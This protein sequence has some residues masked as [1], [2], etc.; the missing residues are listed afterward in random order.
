MLGSSCSPCCA[1]LCSC[2]DTT[3]TYAQ[4]TDSALSA[5]RWC[6]NGSKPSEVTVRLTASSVADTFVSY[7]DGSAYNLPYFDS[8]RGY[9]KK[10]YK[11]TLTIDL[12]TVSAD[13]TLSLRRL[14]SQLYYAYQ[15]AYSFGQ[16]NYPRIFAGSGTVEYPS[17]SQTFPSYTLKFMTGNSSAV[18]M[19][20]TVGTIRREYEYMPYQYNGNGTYSP[21]GGWTRDAGLDTEASSLP[22][23][24]NFV[25]TRSVVLSSQ[26]CD[27]RPLGISWS[28]VVSVDPD[29][30]IGGGIDSYDGVRESSGASPVGG[31]PMVPQFALTVEVLPS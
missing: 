4:Q 29:V 21:T 22:C 19:S 31:G 24:Y 2:G 15:C 10:R 1:Q 12:S 25:V 26:A 28:S 18:G 20:Q 30:L 17:E 6:C 7:Q 16:F 23:S 27:I 5:G 3:K 11:R 14:P 9:Y 13:Y 8:V